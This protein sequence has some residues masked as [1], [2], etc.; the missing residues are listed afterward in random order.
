MRF[1]HASG[2]AARGPAVRRTPLR[3]ILLSALTLLLAVGGT[4]PAVGRTAGTS[5][6]VTAWGDDLFG[7]SSVPSGLSGVAAVSAGEWH[8]M[9]LGSDGTVT[10][11]GDNNHGQATVP[12]ALNGVVAISAGFFHNLALKSDGTVVGWG[13][14]ADGQATVPAGLRGVTAIAAGGFHSLALRSDR[15]VVGWGYNGDEETTVPP[16]L[17]D[18]V[19]IAAGAFHSLALKADGTV[20]AWGYDFYGQ[21]TVPAGLSGVVA[22]AAGAYH[23]LALKADGSVVAWGNDNLRQTAVPTALHGVVAISAGEDHSLALK[24]DGTVAV[25]GSNELGQLLVPAGLHGVVA[26]DAGG[27][28]TLALVAAAAVTLH[29]PADRIVEATGPSGASVRYHVSVTDPADPSPSLRC[30]PQSGSVFALGST[31]VHCTATDAEGHIARGHFAVTV[32]DTRP[33]LIATPHHVRA[34][35]TSSETTLVRYPPIRASDLVSGDRPVSCKPASGSHFP[36]GSTTVI[37]NSTDLAGNKRTARFPVLVTYAW[38]GVLP[39]LHRHGPSVVPAG[40]TVPVAF[41]LCGPSARVVGATAQLSYAAETANPVWISVGTFGF[42]PRH[43]VY[44]AHWRTRGLARG[45]YL[46]KIDLGDS[47]QH[48]VTVSVR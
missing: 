22:I 30:R 37:C 40:R 19:A 9:A 3:L 20:V 13:Y 45:S 21:A 10:A 47:A 12:A 27:Y 48:L 29:L 34:T 1:R 18:V 6:T 33:P 5:G 41:A 38:S 46:L 35:A 16:G 15:T 32:R 17:S 25:W 11:W 44:V 43:R 23:S 8:S 39:P 26:I 28:A 4:V 7:E 2:P 36:L 31:A 42:D 14:N 24:S